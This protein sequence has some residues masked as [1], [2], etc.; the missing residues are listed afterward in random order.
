MKLPALLSGLTLAVCA[1]SCA[2]SPLDDPKGP[3]DRD[4]GTSRVLLSTTTISS[5]ERVGSD[6]DAIQ[7]RLDF[8]SAALAEGR[9]QEARAATTETVANLLALGPMTSDDP[10]VDD[11]YRAATHAQRLGDTELAGRAYTRFLALTRVHSWPEHLR[12]QMAAL[13]PDYRAPVATKLPPT[14]PEKDPGTVV[15]APPVVGGGTVNPVEA[16]FSDEEFTKQA[17]ELDERLSRMRDG[18]APGEFRETIEMSVRFADACCKKDQRK[19]AKATLDKAAAYAGKN[20]GPD[21]AD[22]QAA[23][24][25]LAEKVREVQ[26]P[27]SAADL[28]QQYVASLA[29][30]HT[31]PAD[32]QSARET[33]A[34]EL[35]AAN[36]VAEAQAVAEQS[37]RDGVKD[38]PKEN[39]PSI[40]DKVIAVRTNELESTKTAEEGQPVADGIVRGLALIPQDSQTA[41]AAKRA[42]AEH[43]HRTKDWETALKYRQEVVE[44]LRAASPLDRE[45]LIDDLKFVSSLL[46]DLLRKAES[47]D[48][49]LEIDELKQAGR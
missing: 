45:Q 31:D 41:L 33:L 12:E 5:R 25:Q 7:Q 24:K 1:L 40:L 8:A 16:G 34:G 47:R 27:G 9:L 28:W 23:R 32:M 14:E 18:I 38:A 21:D 39:G 19:R 35:L 46:R 4:T 22:T 3:A 48:I 20:Q 10:R 17:H 49:D 15:P 30:T 37:V 44:V 6:V 29:R 36:R 13:E 26:G 42:L 43:C 11:L 2:S